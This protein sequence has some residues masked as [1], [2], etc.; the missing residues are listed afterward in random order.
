MTGSVEFIAIAGAIF[1]FAAFIHGSVGFGFPMVA[2][3]LLSIFTDVQ[4]AIALTLLP[5]LMINTVS[6]ASE[7]QLTQAVRRYLPLA[8]TAMLGSAVGTQILLLF[9]SALF[10]L[11]LAAAIVLYLLADRAN[12]HLPWVKRQP[13]LSLYLFGMLAGVL[14]G[15]T[16]VMAPVLVIYTLE[17]GYTKGETVQALNL[18]FLLGK[19]VQ[20][21][22]FIGNA[23]Y[24]LAVLE[25]SSLGLLLSAAALA[26]GV[27]LKRL[28]PQATYKLLLKVLLIV[29]AGVL[30]VQAAR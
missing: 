14:G 16:N 7:G 15:L 22:L 28:I 20:L 18:C 10:K 11:L 3:P 29:L 24:E 19:C 17:L 2:T 23:R 30:F 4:T 5:T 8:V 27:R 1:L 21:L 13:R 6:I 25:L 26:L 9:D 12:L